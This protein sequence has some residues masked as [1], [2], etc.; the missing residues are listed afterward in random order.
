M[1]IATQNEIGAPATRQARRE[2][3]YMVATYALPVL[4]AVAA[5]GFFDV[6]PF[7]W[8]ELSLLAVMYSITMLG[9]EGGYHRLFTHRSFRAGA[10]VRAAFAIAGS[11]T[12]QGPVIRWAAVHRLHHDRSDE[13]NDPHS[14]YIVRDRRVGLLRGLWNSSFGWLFVEGSWLGLDIRSYPQDLLKDRL[15]VRLSMSYFTWVLLGLAVPALVGGLLHWSWQGAI[16]GFLWGGLVR[17]LLTHMA[18]ASV[19]SVCHVVGT[20]PFRTGDQSRNNWLLA[21]PTFGESWHNTHHAFP[22][23]AIL[24][25]RWWQPDFCGRIIWLL[26]RFGLVTHV[27]RTSSRMI[28]VKRRS[29]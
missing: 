3:P 7:G 5:I 20:Q 23:V 27:N 13:E 10:A 12:A 21:L 22:G 11:M 8:I 4:G 9:V 1:A 24:A 19:N 26:E 6:L 29:S 17:I 28:A 16:S 2:L 14:P 15:L 18:T 25:L